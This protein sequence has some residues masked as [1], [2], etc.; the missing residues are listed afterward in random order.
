MGKTS[1]SA[2]ADTN[3]GR[4]RTGSESSRSAETGQTVGTTGAVP[5][6]LPTVCLIEDDVD[7]REALRTLLED[8]GY[9]VLEAVDG[10]SGLALLRSHPE[11]LVVLLNYKLPKMDGCALLATVAQDAVL[12]SRHAFIMVT[13]NAHVVLHECGKT[14]DELAVSLVN[15]PFDIA[16]M[17]AAVKQTAQRLTER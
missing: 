4:R 17:L 12:R 16:R 7:I 3:T 10:E 15:K 14:L 9:R 13:A 1:A 5:G 2:D 8:D 11:R 6:L